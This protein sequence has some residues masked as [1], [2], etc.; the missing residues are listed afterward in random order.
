MRTYYSKNFELPGDTSGEYLVIFPNGTKYWYLNG[1][2]HREDGPAIECA[3][4]TK[5]VVS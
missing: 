3:N 1:K 2:F 5:D 4:G